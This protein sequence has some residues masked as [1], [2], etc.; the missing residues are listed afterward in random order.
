MTEDDLTMKG[1]CYLIAWSDP[2]YS[3]SGCSDAYLKVALHDMEMLNNIRPVEA[4]GQK[5]EGGKRFYI[6]LTEI[7]DDEQPVVPKLKGGKLSQ[8]L[9][10][11]LGDEH[12]QEFLRT[13]FS[14]VIKDAAKTNRDLWNMVTIKERTD[15]AV[16]HL[17]S[18]SS[19][20]DIDNNAL[21]GEE[22]INKILNPFNDY[23]QEKGVSYER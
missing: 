20:V 11:R 22:F 15:I 5:K 23:C 2:V 19:K 1:E 17:L 12:F 9:A 4:R 21:V 14:S 7:G 13:N 3:S 6:T 8:W 16:K 10:M 18:I